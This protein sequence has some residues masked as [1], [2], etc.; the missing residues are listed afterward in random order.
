MTGTGGQ[1][2]GHGNSI[3]SGTVMRLERTSDAEYPQ[4]VRG[5]ED[6]VASHREPHASRRRACRQGPPAGGRS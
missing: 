3:V 2:S 5:F 6:G 4:N 1:I